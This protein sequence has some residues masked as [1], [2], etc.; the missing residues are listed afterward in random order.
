MARHFNLSTRF[1]RTRCCSEQGSTRLVDRMQRLA[2][3]RH[4]NWVQ[5]Q[6]YGRLLQRLC[7]ITVGC[8]HNS[9]Q[10]YSHHCS[11]HR[12]TTT[13]VMRSN[14]KYQ[15]NLCLVTE[16]QFSSLLKYSCVVCNGLSPYSNK[17]SAE[18]SNGLSPY[19]DKMS[20][21]PPPQR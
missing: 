16:S 8:N 11:S 5:P 10:G 7:V 12:A 1:P 18:N 6:K 2:F 20:A 19:N 17:M 9:I 21:V 3:L 15:F 4:H 14:T 13:K